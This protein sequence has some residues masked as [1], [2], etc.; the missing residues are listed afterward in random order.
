MTA[1]T[2]KEEVEWRTRLNHAPSH[3]SYL[4]VGPLHFS[5]LALNIKALGAVY[6]K[7]GGCITESWTA[8]VADAT[9]AQ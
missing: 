4:H 8:R 6:G 2:P 1:C 5:S 7:P 3:E 9:Q